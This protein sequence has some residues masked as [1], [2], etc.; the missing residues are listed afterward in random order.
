M[1]SR[2]QDELPAEKKHNSNQEEEWVQLTKAIV[3]ATSSIR[4]GI[5]NSL[6][7][8]RCGIVGS[9]VNFPVFLVSSAAAIV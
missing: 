8:I 1:H 4:E 2:E 9:N 3:V 7:P 6:I 5:R